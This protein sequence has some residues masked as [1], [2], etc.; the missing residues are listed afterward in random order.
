[1]AQVRL[2][3]L[4]LVPAKPLLLLLPVTME[5]TIDERSPLFGH[6]S[7]SLTVRA[8]CSP[9]FV[10]CLVTLELK[11]NNCVKSFA[12]CSLLQACQFSSCCEAIVFPMSEC[13]ASMGWLVHNVLPRR[14]SCALPC[15][16]CQ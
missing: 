15:C 3:A 4:E 12:L 8:G 9:A 10:V 11:R 5:H 2:D 1:M 7:D 13:L 16:A 6:T 14:P